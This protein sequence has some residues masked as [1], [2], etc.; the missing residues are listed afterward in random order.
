MKSYSVM[1]NLTVNTLLIGFGVYLACLALFWPFLDRCAGGPELLLE[2][3]EGRGTVDLGPL[4]GGR[5][6]ARTRFL[7]ETF[8]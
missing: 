3:L 8:A 5:G 6:L 1:K 4:W 2:M 7:I